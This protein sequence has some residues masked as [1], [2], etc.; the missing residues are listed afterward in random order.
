MDRF[1]REL[2]EFASIVTIVYRAWGSAAGVP[3]R[4][5]VAQQAIALVGAATEGYPWPSRVLPRPSPDGHGQGRRQ[6]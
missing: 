6:G 2:C 4:H 5:F 3:H 1:L